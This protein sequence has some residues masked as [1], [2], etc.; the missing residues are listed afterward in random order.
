MPKNYILKIKLHPRE[1][2]NKYKNFIARNIQIVKKVNIKNI[3]FQSE[4]VF[5]IISIYNIVLAKYRND[6]NCFK[7]DTPF[8]FVG[9]H[10]KFVNVIRNDK[11]LLKVFLNKKKLN[12]IKL[13]KNYFIDI[14]NSIS[15][16]K[17]LFRETALKI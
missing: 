15:K 14:K 8:K 6:I 9:E 2:F 7:I 4:Y 10:Y 5:G 1:N 16:I 11:D 3:I 13:A 12:N 17:K